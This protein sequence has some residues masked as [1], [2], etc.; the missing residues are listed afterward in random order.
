MEAKLGYQPSYAWR[1]ILSAKDVLDKGARW[2][3]G[4]GA[5]IKIWKDKWLPNQAGFK[6]WSPVKD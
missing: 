2:R 5:S 1:S 3:V 6:V 4:N